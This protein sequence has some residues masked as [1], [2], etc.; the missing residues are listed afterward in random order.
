MLGKCWYEA[1]GTPKPKR[2]TLVSLDNLREIQSLSV[3][4]R[5]FSERVKLYGKNGENAVF[6]QDGSRMTKSEVVKFAKSEFDAINAQLKLVLGGDYDDFKS[7]S[8][9]YSKALK[10]DWE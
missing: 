4:L 5:L 8:W 6:H 9:K 10:G 7:F 3:L 1:T 2:Q